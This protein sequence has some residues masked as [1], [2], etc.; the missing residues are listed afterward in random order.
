[1]TDVAAD[2]Y[3]T[4]EFEITTADLDRLAAYIGETGQA[5][6]LDS[7]TRRIIRGRLLYGPEQSTPAPTD[8]GEAQVRWLDQV[9][10][11]DLKVGDYLF[12]LRRKDKETVVP[13]LGEVMALQSNRVSVFLPDVQET[14]DY[15]YPKNQAD[16]RTFQENYRRE[17]EK[18]RRQA[19]EKQFDAT[20]VE[21]L[22]LAVMEY[23]DHVAGLLLNALRADDR[24]LLL[25][26]RW[27]LGQLA[28]LPTQAQ[29]AAVAWGL[30]GAAEPQ[31]T[32]NL[33]DHLPSP[34]AA[35]D[36]GL[37]GLYL[38]LRQRPDLF[39][40]ADPGGRPR[41]RLAGPPPGAFTPRQ[42]AYDPENYTILC[43][44]GVAAEP[45]AVQRLWQ[46]ELL[47]AVV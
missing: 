44:P 19:A 34:T 20:S 3:W 30:A 23:G 5:Q 40:N 4:E 21:L 7:L 18:K 11:G 13:Y 8:T 25:S 9:E 24:F 1:M 10:V 12:F 37:F 26:G 6:E 47:P 27:F 35:G 22:D 29:V 17:R 36:R 38:A 15:Q 39:A 16:W 42:A 31:L 2:R 45:A 43:R 32:E 41:W 14:K 28:V 33:F 46:L